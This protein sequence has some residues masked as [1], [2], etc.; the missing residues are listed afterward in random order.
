MN[1]Y[2][3]THISLFVSVLPVPSF[4]TLEL[5]NTTVMRFC[6]DFLY[7]FLNEEVLKKLRDEYQEFCRD[8]IGK[9]MCS[10]SKSRLVVVLK[11]ETMTCRK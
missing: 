7:Y 10:L 11:K 3:N 8:Q 9:R 2:K 4:T 5:T 6:Q 1:K